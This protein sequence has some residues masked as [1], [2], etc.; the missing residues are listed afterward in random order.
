VVESVNGER[1]RGTE[2]FCSTTG[3]E[4][5]RTPGELKASARGALNIDRSTEKAA[6]EREREGRNENMRARARH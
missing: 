2:A 4:T 6:R 5:G 1:E 3:R